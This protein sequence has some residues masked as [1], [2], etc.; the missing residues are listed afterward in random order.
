MMSARPRVLLLGAGRIG[1]ALLEG[2]LARHA[3]EG[4][5]LVIEPT[6]T[7]ALRAYAKEGRIR[8]NPWPGANTP[9]IAVMAI[10]PQSFD[11]G[12]NSLAP[13]LSP[14]TAILSVAAGK[15]IQTIKGGLGA[16]RRIVRAMPN[17]PAA[18][19][20]GITVACA[21]PGVGETLKR[22]CTS[23]LEAV[24]VV[25]WIE[26]EG[27]MDA[28]TALSGSG[29]AYLFYLCECLTQ[30][31]IAEGLAPALAARL[32]RVTLSGAGALLEARSDSPEALRSEVTSPGGTTEAA[33]KVLMAKDGLEPLFRRA[34]AAAAERGR[35]LA[36]VH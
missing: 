25:E 18:I 29:P 34:L 3:L 8:H 17:T 33:L 23:L 15:T 30:A 9:D 11:S 7:A 10:K 26:D 6:P 24:G 2:W 13:Y 1:T 31:G 14:S 19:G 16:D 12:F 20:K 5:P 21:G 36:G 32:A 4:P 35:A 27:L 28:V 22:Q